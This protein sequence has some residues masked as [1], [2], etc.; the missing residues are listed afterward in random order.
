M[1]SM[2][3]L[4]FFL[5]L[6][7]VWAGV[8]FAQEMNDTTI[9][10]ESLFREMIDLERLTRFPDPAYRTVQF[11]SFDRRSSLPGGPGWFANSDGFGGEPIPNFEKTLKTPGPDGIGEYLVADLKGP[12]AVVRLWS[13]AISGK[14]RLYIDDL[15]RPLYAGE[16]AP[17]FRRTYACFSESGTLDKDLLEKTIYQRDAAYTPLPFRKSLRIV[18]TGN[19]KEIHFYQV[20]VRLYEPGAKV[21]SFR[22]QDLTTSGKVINEVL[23]VLAN[24][25]ARLS[26]SGDSP[27]SFRASL[28]PFE[29]REI[30]S[31]EGPQA[32]ERLA[33]KLESEDMGRALRKTILHIICDDAPWGQVQSP[34]GDFFGAAPGINPCVSLPFSVHP[35]GTMA[36]RFPMPFRKSLRILLENMGDAPVN[37][38]GSA[39]VR[40]YRWDDQRSMH[41]RA[42]WRVD[43]GLIASN[44]EVQDLPFILARGEGL[45]VGTASFIM[46]PSPVPTPYGSWWGE[47][48]EKVF[49]DGDRTP[50]TFGTGSEDYYNYSW[51]SPDIFSYPYCGQPRND[52]PGNRGFVTNFRWHV[53]DPFPFR[54]AISFF[55]EL[56]SHE[57]TPG[58]SYA[59][60]GYYYAR[61]GV[62]DDH[63]PITPEDVR[64]LDLPAWE[65]AA[66]MGA[67]DFE[68]FSAE[69]AVI[70]ADGTTLR[71]GRIFSGGTALIWVP[72]RVGDTKDFKVTVNEA[73]KKRIQCVFVLA[74][75]MG[76]VSA[77][78]D[79]RPVFWADSAATI[80]LRA[81]G[82][83]LLR[84]V[85]LM[86]VELEA[87][88]HVLTLKFEGADADIQ[89]PEV[90]LDFIGIQNVDK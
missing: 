55:L 80:N 12:G 49:V 83:T 39:L 28:P 46:N 64:T 33:L 26:S 82:R 77:L 20:G 69:K 68:F 52:G 43:H 15:N 24:P 86:P 56:Y 7:P 13:A 16:A 42:R 84:M 21:V 47:G 88:E 48:D 63:R 51:S 23:A 89:V 79:R 50:S 3:R 57:R 81:P 22:P 4:L 19:L 17:F 59:R 10:T 30:L 37:A 1:K 53:L 18:W 87:G 6:I 76:T 8:D 40:S 70:D 31:L 61:P 66:R 58:L 9:T 67:R 90:G 34:V 25:E 72:E 75:D 45:Y 32:I 85:S 41:F 74:D 73:G 65:P 38:S 14:V 44:R 29:K 5:F 35:D 62:F 27:F 11:S 60:I 36:C 2:P 78:I 54:Q 71:G